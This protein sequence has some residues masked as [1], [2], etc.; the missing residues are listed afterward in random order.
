MSSRVPG[1]ACPVWL[2]LQTK[3]A[4]IMNDGVVK[5]KNYQLGV[6][7]DSNLLVSKYIIP[8]I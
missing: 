3:D 2:P 7:E 1:M 4:A 5:M 6:F 8:H